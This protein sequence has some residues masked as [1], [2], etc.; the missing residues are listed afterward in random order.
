MGHCANKKVGEDRRGT[1]RDDQEPINDFGS[2][3][4]FGRATRNF[5]V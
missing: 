4:E 5:E 2:A 3:I 1:R